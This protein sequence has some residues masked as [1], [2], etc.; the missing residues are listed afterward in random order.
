[1]RNKTAK[2][3]TAVCHCFPKKNTASPANTEMAKALI[4]A[5]CTGVRLELRNILNRKQLCCQQ[6]KINED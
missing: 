6:A 2:L 3:P 5:S 4:A 1:M